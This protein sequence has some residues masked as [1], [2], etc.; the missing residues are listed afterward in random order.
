MCGEMMGKDHMMD[1]MEKMHIGRK[2]INA[3]NE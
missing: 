1:T 2:R 3:E